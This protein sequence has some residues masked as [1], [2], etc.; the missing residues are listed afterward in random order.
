M[1][2][3]REPGDLKLGRFILVR[4]KRVKDFSF[5]VCLRIGP[6]PRH[7]LPTPVISTPVS[8]GIFP[9]IFFHVISLINVHLSRAELKQCPPSLGEMKLEKN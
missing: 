2:Y 9:K 3:T 8:L 1:R 7:R 5:S 4:V 6:R